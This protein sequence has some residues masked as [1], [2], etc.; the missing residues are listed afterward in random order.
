MP[1]QGVER[2]PLRWRGW[3]AA[4][5]IGVGAVCGSAS[6][7]R[8]TRQ[9]LLAEW[10]VP[11]RSD[12]LRF[13]NAAQT[14]AEEEVVRRS[15]LRAA[16]F[17]AEEWVNKTADRLGLATTLAASRSAEDAFEKRFL[18]PFFSER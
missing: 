7:A 3:Y 18:T 12:W 1:Q 9:V 14:A 2:N 6:M 11:R 17:G 16:P 4:P 15:V 13:V 5:K 8:P 10:P